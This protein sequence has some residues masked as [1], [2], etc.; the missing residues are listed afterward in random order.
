MSTK[1]ISVAELQTGSAYQIN[2]AGDYQ[3]DFSSLT[4]N[5]SNCYIKINVTG[6]NIFGKG[7]TGSNT[8]PGIPSGQGTMFTLDGRSDYSGFILVS[9]NYYTVNVYGIGFAPSVNSTIKND[10]S[11]FLNGYSGAPI[12]NFYNCE[13]QSTITTDYSGGL[14]GRSCYASFYYCVNRGEVASD[15]SGGITGYESYGFI[16]NCVNYGK[17]S[18]QYCGGIV[19]NYYK[20]IMSYCIN[21]GEIGKNNAGICYYS[22]TSDDSSPVI[23][24]SCTNNG[25]ID[26]YGV[27]IIYKNTA[28]VYLCTSTTNIIYPNTALLC[29][30][31]SSVGVINECSFTLDFLYSNAST[32]SQNFYLLC[33]ENNDGVISNCSYTG[34]LNISGE[35]VSSTTNLE[36]N[37]GCN[38]YGIVGGTNSGTLSNIN[39]TLNECLTNASNSVNVNGKDDN[40]YTLANGANGGSVYLLCQENTGEITNVTFTIN[41]QLNTAGGSCTSTEQINNA[42]NYSG[43][44]G[45]KGGNFMVINKNSASLSNVYLNLNCGTIYVSGG[46]SV[47]ATTKDGQTYSPRQGYQPNFYFCYENDNSILNSYVYNFLHTTQNININGSFNDIY[48]YSP[49]CGIN[50]TSAVI[51]QCFCIGNFNFDNPNSGV[52]YAGGIAAKNYGTVENSFMYGN[53]GCVC[54]YYGGIVGYSDGNIQNCYYCGLPTTSNYPTCGGICGTTTNVILNCYSCITGNTTNL[55]IY[56]IAPCNFTLC[57]SNEYSW[58]ADNANS[59]LTGIPTSTIY[60][61]SGEIW[62]IISSSDPYELTWYYQITNNN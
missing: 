26:E 15:Y 24:E 30:S 54:N 11:I 35:V 17:I 33:M 59:S 25:T 16:Q 51:N 20:N 8:T 53:F 45:G 44:V 14:G 55:T 62:T 46:I 6:V 23:I 49:F 37:A 9:E 60:P 3:F 31:N 40:N 19:S 28:T 57:K 50:N 22:F 27:G 10:C 5:T 41:N 61:A 7:V 52:S 36:G 2:V 29:Y 34:S 43:G 1:T 39:I 13:N 58:N 18:G 21:Y 32:S 56:P 47:T 12:A 42:N 4:I 38:F 48:Y